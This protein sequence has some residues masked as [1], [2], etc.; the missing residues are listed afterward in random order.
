M[1]QAF[2]QVTYRRGRAL[3]AYYYLPRPEGAR[4]VRTTEVESGLLVDYD[5]NGTPLG[6]EIADPR[7]VTLDAM[8]RVFASLGLPAIPPEEIAPLSAA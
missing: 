5:G 8:N 7:A 4:S 3:A 6:I 1:D 2:L